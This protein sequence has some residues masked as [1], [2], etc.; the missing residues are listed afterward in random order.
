MRTVLM[1]TIVAGVLLAGGPA[2]Q[3]QPAADLYRSAVE[4]EEV[5]GD[6]EKA[7]AA[8]RTIL[9]RFASDRP[10]A[11]KAQLQLARCYERLG[12]AEARAAYEAVIRQ[13]SDQPDP[14]AQARARLAGLAGGSGVQAA[15]GMIAK[16]VWSGPEVDLQGRPSLDGR[17]LTYVDWTST[18]T[19]NVAVRDLTTG[20]NRRLT[21][22]QDPAEGFAEYPVLSPDGRTVAYTWDSSVRL[23]GVDG[24][25]PRVLAPRRGGEYPYDLAWSPDGRLLAAAVTDYGTD[26]T[27]YLALISA[28]DGTTTRLKST[29]WHSPAVGG[30]S[31]DGKI[32]LYDVDN[33]KG[34]RDVVAIAADGSSETVVVGGPS[35]D[36]QATWTADGRAIVFVSDRSGSPALWTV[37]VENGVPRGAAELVRP[38]IGPISALGFTRDGSYLYGSQNG[39]QDIYV[40]R[41]DPV[42]LAVTAS[43]AALTDRFVGSNSA[44]SA[45]P[46]GRFIAFVRGPDRRSKSLVIRSIA[47]GVERTLNTKLLDGFFPGQIGAAWFP[48]S[49]SLLVTDTDHADRKATFRRVDIE[50]GKEMLLFD[51]IYQTVWPIVAI[52]PD[53]RS[54]FFTRKE[55]HTDP[56]MNRLHLVRRDIASG[57][58]TEL[59]SAVSDGAG[60][61]ALTISPD[62][63]RLA[64]MANVGPNQR[65]LLTL[66]SDGGTPTV[67]YRGGYSNPQPQS[68]VWTR[69]GRHILFKA[70]DGQRRTRVWAIPSDGGEPRK[71]D[72]STE[73]NIV[74]MDLSPD[75]T[76]LMFTGTIRKPELW[77]I[78]NLL[79]VRTSQK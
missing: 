1:M 51:A 37:T 42:T 53:G 21:D 8:Y 79:P 50:T 5:K 6:L 36:S 69:D 44:P 45:S 38:N 47:D 63:R 55:S 18:R 71:L 62:G 12:K 17:Y 16:Q 2:A 14:V 48:D 10:V 67:L 19:G 59:Y 40:A 41:L 32:L 20:T 66:P 70:Q 7:I 43:P 11:A 30:F 39:Q 77:V 73:G 74:R 46:D 57:S 68:A 15:T 35:N 65:H 24:S 61:F 31:R 76:Q 72:L 49:K 33:A 23:I 34:D 52:A 3:G 78:K 56:T 60:F 29:S 9:E 58:E 25:R 13:Y 54:L 64:F 75:G 27:S 26:R 28:A 4:L 22:A